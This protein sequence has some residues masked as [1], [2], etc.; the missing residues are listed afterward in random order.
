MGQKAWEDRLVTGVGVRS[1]GGG[2]QPDRH[3]DKTTDSGVAKPRKKNKEQEWEDLIS[4]P[5]SHTHTRPI[6]SPT[7]AALLLFQAK[8]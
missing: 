2:R 6:T 7:K 3:G 1:E 8:K 5:Q 4:F